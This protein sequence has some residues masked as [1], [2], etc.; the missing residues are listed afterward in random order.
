MLF[1]KIF[2]PAALCGCLL[3]SCEG[4][5]DSA[6]NNGSSTLIDSTN[7]HGTAPAVYGADDPANDQDTTYANSND[8]GTRVS[9]GPDNTNRNNPSNNQNR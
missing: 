7:Q 9:Q 8:T 1:K 2:L 3:A 4:G 5:H 6:D